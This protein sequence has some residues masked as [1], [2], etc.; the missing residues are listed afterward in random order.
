MKGPTR[1]LSVKKIR[2]NIEESLQTNDTGKKEKTKR[3]YN[4]IIVERERKN[5][6]INYVNQSRQQIQNVSKLF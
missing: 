4:S 2:L 6:T 1:S 3:N 5:K